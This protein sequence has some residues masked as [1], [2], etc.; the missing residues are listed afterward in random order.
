MQ[1]TGPAFMV[2]RRNH[3]PLLSGDRNKFSVGAA[4]SIALIASLVLFSVCMALGSSAD[5]MR[6]SFLILAFEGSVIALLIAVK[7]HYSGIRLFEPFTMVTVVYTLTLFVAPVIEFGLGSVSRFG[8]D[9]SGNT[10]FATFAAT[11]GYIAFFA[12]YELYHPAPPRRNA[13]RRGADRGNSELVS[14]VALVLWLLAY[15]LCLY[16]YLK[17]GYG[18]SYILTAGFGGDA[19]GDVGEDSLAFL[20]YAKYALV[21]CWMCLFAHSSNKPVLV[22]TYVLSAGMLLFGGSRSSLLLILIAPLAYHYIRAGREP[23]VRSVLLAVFAL[24]F[25]FAAIQVARNGV[26]LG[27]GFSLAGYSLSEM[28]TPYLNEVEGFKIYYALFDVFPE[29][30]GHLL[31]S[32]MFGYTLVMLI[33]RAIWPGKPDA[34]IHEIVC[35]AMGLQALQ[36]G[37][38]YPFIGELFVEFGIIGCFVG[39]LLFGLLCKKLGQLRFC[40]GDDKFRLIAYCLLYPALFQFMIR[41]YFPSNCM[42]LIFLLVPV[43]LV[44][45]FSLVRKGSGSFSGAAERGLM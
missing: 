37:N 22:L 9:V 1:E 26:K 43:L 34:V 36:S 38:S 32:Q 14:K 20:A 44:D 33:P 25:V 21:G 5:K 39:M 23:R 16:N 2:D 8:I 45:C 29:K 11:L 15:A 19:A 18:L 7:S 30:M 10:L 17:R 28:F 4:I 24:V 12:G 13:S 27:N 31:G 6:D 41:G 42:M 35:Q 3:A 40:D